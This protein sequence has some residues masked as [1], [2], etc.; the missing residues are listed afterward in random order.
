MTNSKLKNKSTG[1]FVGRLSTWIGSMTFLASLF[2]L[3]NFGRFLEMALA[4][5]ARLVFGIEV[6][7]IISIPLIV[8]FFYDKIKKRK[9]ETK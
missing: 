2:E 5:S 1:H 3:L 8:K 4:F 9:E 6:I 7:V